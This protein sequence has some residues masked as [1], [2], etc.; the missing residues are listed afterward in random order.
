MTPVIKTFLNRFAKGLILLIIIGLV[1]RLFFYDDVKRWVSTKVQDYITELDYGDLQMDNLDLS[2]FQHFPN[3]SVQ[4]NKVR[5]YEEKDSVRPDHIQPILYTEQLNLTFSSWELIRHKNLIVTTLESENGEL[6]LLTYE[7]NTTN[8]ERAFNTT[9]TQNKGAQVS[10]KDSLEYDGNKSNR[11][12][13]NPDTSNAKKELLSIALEAVYFNN[14]ILSYTNPCENFT[15]QVKLESLSGKLLLNETGLSCDL[16]SSFEISK[17]SEFPMIAE[18][19]PAALGLNLDFINATEVIVI[20]DGSIR[21]KTITADLKGSYNNS[22]EKYIDIKFDASSND[23]AFLSKVIK[24]DVLIQNSA[25]VKKMDIILN[26][27]IKGKMEDNFPKID[28][29]F[30]VSD[31]SLIIPEST[32]KFTNIG[33]D[34]ELHTGEADDFSGAQLAVRNLRGKL[35]GGSMSG[36]FIVRNFKNPN[37][38]SSM[39]LSLDLDDLDNIFN[40]SSIDSLKGK[41]HF[42][43]N[44]DGKINT[45]D[46]HALDGIN[47][48]SLDLED[49]GFKYIPTNKHIDKLHGNMSETNNEVVLHNLSMRYDNSDISINGRIKNLYHFIFSKEQNIEAELELTSSQFYTSHFL[50]SPNGIPVIDERL[51]NLLL[52][53][54]ILMTD[55]NSYDSYFPKINAEVTKLSFDLDTLPNVKDLNGKIAFEQTKNSF[56]FDLKDMIGELPF[57]KATLNAKVL[58]PNDFQ[59]LDVNANMDISHLPLDYVQDLIYEMIDLDLLDAKH[60]NKEEMTLVDGDLHLSGILE[61]FP[62]ATHSAEITSNVLSFH[63]EDSSEYNFENLNM[64]LD[65]LHFL[66]DTI[67]KSITGIKTTHGKLNVASLDLA[68]IK[69]IPLYINFEGVNDKLKIDLATSRGALSN[70]EGNLNLDLSGDT[71]VFDL[72]YNRKDISAKPLIEDYNADIGINGDLNAALKLSGKGSN[73]EDISSSLKGD[74]EISSDSLIFNG[75]D[76]DGLLKKYH[77][78]QKFNL[79]DLSAYVIAGPFGAVVTKGSDFTSLISADLKPEDKTIISKALARWS[80]NDGILQSEDVAFS[81][82]LSRVAFNGSLDIAKD[83]IPGFTV[84]VVDKNG[85]SLMQQTISGKTDDIQIGKLKL[86]KTLLGSIINAVKSVVGSNCEIVYDGEIEHPNSIK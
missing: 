35:P 13:V 45:E 75:I 25:L 10:K 74:I 8:L 70:H 17:S 6:N 69:H 62:F 36:N 2:V 34:G 20:R 31:L 58:I 4:L 41:V 51:S 54:K 33:F 76:L 43:S 61:L 65:S 30:S 50:F 21:F 80:L 32:G 84:Y 11:P 57:G 49:I 67:S 15:S 5:F 73:I 78:S 3:I 47:R 63:R 42:T 39:N 77:R 38:K 23:L 29:N 40:I 53:T 27:H 16:K 86:A 18:L 14:F 26:G 55:N 59:T 83:S 72:F 9:A 79:S 64:Q 56:V 60:R 48:W 46:Q 19:G 7:D 1:I 12:V 52:Q 68:S 24:E 66:H 81:T 28:L 71:L 85:C 22:N 37:L 82:N 44:I